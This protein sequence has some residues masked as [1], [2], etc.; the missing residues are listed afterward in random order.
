MLVVNLILEKL[1][2]NWELKWNTTIMPIINQ[3]VEF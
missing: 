3:N 2:S 1:I